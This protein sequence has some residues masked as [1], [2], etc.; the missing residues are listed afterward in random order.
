MKS[1]NDIIF[2]QVLLWARAGNGLPSSC[3]AEAAE[4][5]SEASRARCGKQSL[6][7][8]R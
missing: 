8:Q 4:L 3:L 2:I 5:P 6:P 7:P 1:V